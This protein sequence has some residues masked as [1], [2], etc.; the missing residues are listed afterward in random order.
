MS[1]GRWNHPAPPHVRGCKFSL[2]K[3]RTSAGPGSWDTLDLCCEHSWEAFSLS[4][5]LAHCTGRPISSRG[6]AP[7]SPSRWRVCRCTQCAQSRWARVARARMS[8][9]VL[10]R[11]PRRAR[12]RRLGQVCPASAQ[13]GQ[14][15]QF[16]YKMYQMN[17]IY[18]EFRAHL[19]WQELVNF[20]NTDVCL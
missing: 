9:S 17:A 8:E 14:R 12:P 11:R 18:I 6:S 16:R 7:T 19:Y 5:P 13:A 4:L 20:G 15:C 1:C 2:E 3:L 10:Q